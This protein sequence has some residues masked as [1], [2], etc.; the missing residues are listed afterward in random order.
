[1]EAS[2]FEESRFFGAIAAS[3]ARALLI[4]R[5]AMIALGLPVMTRDYDFW[6]A[7]DD[8]EI[9]NTA[10][11]PLGL[12]PN[13]TPEEAR[14]L[15]RYV[16]EN[17]EHVDILVAR[18]VHTVD[19]QPVAFEDVWTNR[20]ELEVAPETLIAVPCIEH[21]IATKRFGSRPRDADD[22]RMLEQLRDLGKDS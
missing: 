19:G 9:F 12:M 22:I 1:V 7:A 17:D 2:E 14:R 8:A 20:R 5:R 16:L 15:G 3:G 11:A 18:L 21:L 6:V 4:G 13:R 10:V